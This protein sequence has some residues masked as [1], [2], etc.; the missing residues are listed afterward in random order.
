MTGSRVLVT[1]ATGFVGRALLPVLIEAG[2]QV[3]ALARR[4]PGDLPPG[5]ELRPVADLGGEVD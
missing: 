3:V 1:G 2:H 5:I 4:D